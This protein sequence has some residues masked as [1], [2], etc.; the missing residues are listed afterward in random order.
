M[1]SWI[2]FY[3]SDHSIYVNRHHRDVHFALIAED[4]G[5]LIAQ[6]DAVVLDYS[7]GEALRAPD[8][9]ARC[10]KLILAEPAPGVRERVAA[11][12]ADQP[13]IEVVSLDDLRS[14]PA[15]T[16][17]LAV[18]NSVSQYMTEG[19]IT[20][21]FAILARLLRPGGRL[22]VGD[23][24][25]PD[26]G[27]VRDAAAL[28]GFGARHGFLVAAFAG[29]VR[30]A[31]SDYRKVRGALGLTTYQPEEMLAKLRA[32]GFSA[33]QRPKNLGHNP[34]RMTFE[35]TLPFY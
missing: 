4:F 16:V 12:F 32:A 17:D 11:R 20:E 30:T 33:I 13:R 2:D 14:R 19:Q 27:P 1:S 31:L 25:R 6:P 23:V 28:L 24:V 29:L 10:G 9:A 15:D 22:I 26:V 5:R 3:D 7:C 35:A 18:M 34:W 21:A 8:I